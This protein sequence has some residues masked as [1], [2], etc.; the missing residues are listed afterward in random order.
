[1]KET[2]R[3]DHPTHLWKYPRFSTDW[4]FANGLHLLDHFIQVAL[5]LWHSARALH[6]LPLFSFVCVLF[7]ATPARKSTENKKQEWRYW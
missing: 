1:M 4:A 2:K 3:E 6:L 7:L 5:P